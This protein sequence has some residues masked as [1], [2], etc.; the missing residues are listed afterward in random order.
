MLHKNLSGELDPNHHNNPLPIGEGDTC[1]Y[2]TLDLVVRSLW[3]E[4]HVYL[5]TNELD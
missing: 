3:L 2:K 4:K 5:L 1:N